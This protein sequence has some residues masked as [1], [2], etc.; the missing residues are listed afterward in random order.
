M[1]GTIEI[2]GTG[3]IIEGNLGAANV[4]VNLDDVLHFDGTDD[5]ID[6]NITLSTTFD[7][8]FTV[9]TW[10]KLD[11]GQGTGRRI[12]G[13]RNSASEDWVQ[14]MVESSGKVSLYYESNN[15]STEAMTNSVI[16]PN[17]ETPWVHI[18]ATVPT[19]GNIIIYINGVAQ[20]LD[21]T[22]DGDMSGITVGDF[23]TTTD[24]F[25]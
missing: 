5:K 16:F 1:T 11:D 15:N 12:L 3:G 20:S 2:T 9:S 10:V 8:A 18:A 24:L 17:G 22:K 7:G 13:S 25:I 19:S 14:L 21:G 6:T 23:S 4:N